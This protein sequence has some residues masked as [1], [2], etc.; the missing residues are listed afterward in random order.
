MKNQYY[1]FRP[2]LSIGIG[3][4]KRLLKREDDSQWYQTEWGSRSTQDDDY[5]DN[6]EKAKALDWY[7]LKVGNFF[8]N[9]MKKRKFSTW[10]EHP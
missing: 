9:L 1:W 10:S 6:L 8:R 7:K 2:P 3:K 4:T 5:F